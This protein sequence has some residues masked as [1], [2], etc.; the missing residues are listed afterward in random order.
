VWKRGTITTDKTR[1]LEAVTTTSQ[2]TALT[3]S[4]QMRP[5]GMHAFLPFTNVLP[6]RA[7]VTASGNERDGC[8]SLSSCSGRRW[9]GARSLRSGWFAGLEVIATAESR[10]SELE[11]LKVLFNAQTECQVNDCRIRFHLPPFAV[12]AQA[13]LILRHER[14]PF[15]SCRT[16]RSLHLQIAKPQSAVFDPS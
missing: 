5:P 11:F 14:I 9:C 12:L 7:I 13:P 15:N 1:V 6:D 8:T 16:R 3:S 10:N 2:A 4:S